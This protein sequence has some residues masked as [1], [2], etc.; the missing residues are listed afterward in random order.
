M[1]EAFFIYKEVEKAQGKAY[2]HESSQNPFILRR[3]TGLRN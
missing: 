3:M 2:I 1:F